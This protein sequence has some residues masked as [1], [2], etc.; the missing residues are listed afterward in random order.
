M[1]RRM[2]NVFTKTL[3]NKYFAEFMALIGWSVIMLV[4]YICRLFLRG[5]CSMDVKTARHC[6]N[7]TSPKPGMDY[8]VHNREKTKDLSIIIPA[9]NA[10]STIKECIGSII[11]QKTKYDYEV[12][13]IDDGS[14]DNTKELVEN[15]TDN[16]LILIH[17]E[18]RGFSGARNRGIDESVGKYI[19]FVDADDCLVGNS[20]EIMMNKIEREDADIVQGSYF[21][22]TGEMSNRQDTLLKAGVIENNA[23]EVVKNPG[24]PWAKIY[25]AGLFEK[26]RFPLDVWFEDTIVCMLLYRMCS[27]MAVMEE[28]V[29]AYRIN[30]EGITKKARHSKKC[31]DHYWVMEHVLEKA[32]ELGLWDDE[33]QYRLVRGH[34]STLL[35]RRI[36]LMDERVKESAFVLACEML[37]EIRPKNFQQDED[38]V[39]LRDIENAFK[40]RNYRLWKMA[41]FVV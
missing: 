36:S 24:F 6:L 32:H 37:D 1:K 30:P 14:T 23:S 40:T 5:K 29:Y 34:M 12:I 21:S 9:Y 22:F 26:I 28:M 39:I 4:Y 16:H 17:Q 10:S 25:K 27:K 3:K 8:D 13:V 15:I 31:V 7:G 11:G 41:S 38:N 2:L 18:N 35:Y 33:I 20:I 19:M